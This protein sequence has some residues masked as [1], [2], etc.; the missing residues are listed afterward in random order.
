MKQIHLSKTW[1]LLLWSIVSTFLLSANLFAQN[2][3][4]KRVTG[5]VTGANDRPVEGA[6]VMVKGT[7]N[8]TST[9][10]NGEFAINAQTGDVLVASSV[11]FQSKEARVG[12]SAIISFS[13]EETAG[14]MED[15]VVIGYGR[16]KKTD[17]SSSQVTVTSADIQKTVNTTIDQA[18]QGRAANVYVSS[19]SGQPGAPPSVVIRGLSSLT[20]NTQPLYVID[21][22]Q[23]K[24]GNPGSNPTSNA[25]SGLN[26][27][28]VETMNILQGPAATAIYGAAGG[29]GVILITTKRGKAGET[30]IS[31]NSL[32]TVQDK[33][34][35]IDVMNLQQYATYRNEIA[36]AGGTASD[37]L[38]ADPSVLG[39]GTD[40]Q[41][42]LF[43]RTLLQKHGLSLSGGSDKTTF[44]F[45]TEY[46]N[47]EGIAPGS[48]FTRGSIRFNLDNQTRKW[49]KIGTSLSI[50]QTQEKVNT[51]NAGIINL[52]IQQNP[53]VPVKN[54]NG[55]WG[56]PP[57]TQFAFSN[58][59]ALATINDDRNKAV[60]FIG[61]AYADITLL[62]GLVLRNEVN[63]NMGYSNSYTFH[64]SYQ[65]GGFINSS[66]KSTRGANN[67]Y[68][69]SFNT[70]LNYDININDHSISI[71]GGHESQQYG[72][73]SLSGE[74]EGFVINDFQDLNNGSSLTAANSSG[75]GKGAQESYFG[76][77]NYV[78][79][80][81]Y[82]LQLTD[83]Y[84][85]SSNFGA[86][87]RWANFPAVSAAWRVSQ[88]KFMQNV[89]LVN[90]LKL[91][92]EY[93]FSGNSSGNGIY[94]NLGTVPT[95][96][97][98][99][100]LASNFPNPNLQWEVTKTT[101]VG[102]DLHMLNNRIEV[103]ADAYIKK[104]DKLLTVNP[105]AF[106]NGGDISYSP[107]YLQWPTTNVGAMQDVGFGITVN[108]VN[109]TN[110]NFTWR[111]GFN[112][113]H[114]KNKILKLITPINPT[115]NTSQ[116]QFLSE[117]GQPASMIT[118]YI[119]EGLFTSYDDIKNHARQT[120]TGAISPSGTWVGDIK[121]KDISGPKGVPD[122]VIDQY[123]RTVIGNPWPKVTLGF[124]NSFSYKNFDLNVFI[125]ATLGN[126]ILN[127]AR[128]QNEQPTGTGTYGNYYASV[129]N[130]AR[131]SSYR[132]EDSISATL[133]NPGNRI[134]RIAPGDP[135]GNNKINQ[136]NIE[137]GSYMRIKNVSLAYNLPKSVISGLGIQGIRVVANVQNLLTITKYKGY[138]PESALAG[139]GGTLISG[140]DIGRYP[141][142]RMYSFNVIV[143]F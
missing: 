33:P 28:D 23:I 10:T 11:G 99:G 24:P 59:I 56:G 93:G 76:R 131:P 54:P 120:A 34:A 111:T 31:A 5:R 62:K 49:L 84:D 71:M 92:V 86:N 74:R 64:P 102:F 12:N 143:N 35:H 121:F 85:G 97:G 53:S 17:L 114:D 130:F 66:T 30:R 57:T 142:V 126:D 94:A 63:G 18:L 58:P 15:V 133:L 73:E 65:F 61:S 138:D 88:E 83:R 124:N 26:P 25:L 78:Y 106:Y 45:S 77:I 103:I 91:R 37:S 125:V 90:D 139:Y 116:A 113:S 128:Y 44:F 50:N 79:N 115:Y 19:A 136:W 69:M 13:L 100:F 6:T 109:I 55:T 48:G 135:N 40:W 4:P 141:A 80:N 107:G 32:I 87:K 96:W 118:G 108:T 16:M 1:R 132:A 122:N 134:P 51:S 42:A 14:K 98:T 8:A 95:G 47:Q 52:A 38:F 3:I 39:A 20:G 117:E 82:I 29:S 89:P 60:G 41:D 110:K 137:S 104:I 22:V 129:S 21:G 68:W 112:I 123:D 119:A 36:N 127:Y 7:A 140:I 43:R 72:N 81:R 75:H 27:D 67:N 9:S 101:N 46:F 70:R 2:S 105:Y